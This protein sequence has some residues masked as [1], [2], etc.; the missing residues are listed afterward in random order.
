M[1]WFDKLIAELKHHDQYSDDLANRLNEIQRRPA[2][3]S[4]EF[5]DLILQ[6]S[7]GRF[8]GKQLFA[9]QYANAAEKQ[10]LSDIVRSGEEAVRQFTEHGWIHVLPSLA[11]YITNVHHFEE[12]LEIGY[13]ALHRAL[14]TY[15]HLPGCR[16]QEYVTVW[17]RQLLEESFQDNSVF[18]PSLRTLVDYQLYVENELELKL[19][20]EP[21]VEEVALAMRYLPVKEKREILAERSR[22]QTLSAMLEQSLRLA[23]TKVLLVRQYKELAKEFTMTLTVTVDG[24]SHFFDNVVRIEQALAQE[25]K[26][27]YRCGHSRYVDKERLKAAPEV[28]RCSKCRQQHRTEGCGEW[29]EVTLLH[30][31]P[32][33]ICLWLDDGRKFFI[34]D[35]FWAIA[36]QLSSSL[37]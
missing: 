16:F 17:I 10:Q 12:L 22:Q 18:V 15:H 37:E 1:S 32:E 26:E 28:W 24:G 6:I 31:H 29:K 36:R 19:N 14:I 35:D 25:V 9:K 21:T 13:T 4:E 33:R 7:I 30:R 3:S 11:D 34:E 23:M 8:A 27:L 20:R 2:L 5:N